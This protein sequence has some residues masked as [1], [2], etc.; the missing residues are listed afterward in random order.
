MPAFF[1]VLPFLCSFW[2]AV[3][4]GEP[5]KEEQPDAGYTHVT[6]MLASLWNGWK[7]GH[8][9]MEDRPGSIVRGSL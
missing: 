2:S 9:R 4:T 6:A 8:N 5:I 3:R 1:A 7:M